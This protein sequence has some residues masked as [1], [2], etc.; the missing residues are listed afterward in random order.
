MDA[1]QLP[2]RRR[3]GGS[4]IQPQ[5]P[6]KRRQRKGAADDV[7]GPAPA[8]ICLASS[9]ICARTPPAYLPPTFL[10]YDLLCSLHSH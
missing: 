4:C 8:P 7:A 10:P 1:R 5:P 2:Q 3:K 6:G 9:Q